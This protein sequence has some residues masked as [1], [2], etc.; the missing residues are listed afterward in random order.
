M[1]VAHALSMTLGTEW[2][3]TLSYADPRNSEHAMELA[4]DRYRFVLDRPMVAEP[5]T[6]WSTMGAPRLFWGG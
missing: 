1:T 5:G 6:K 4:E 2:D 3:E